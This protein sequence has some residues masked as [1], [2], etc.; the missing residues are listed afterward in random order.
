MMLPQHR[1]AA[2]TAAFVPISL[3]ASIVVTTANVTTPD[4]ATSITFDLASGAVATTLDTS[5]TLTSNGFFLDFYSH[6][7]SG[8]PQLHGAPGTSQVM[9]E[10][11]SPTAGGFPSQFA[12]RLGEGAAINGTANWSDAGA[13]GLLSKPGFVP[14][15]PAGTRGYAGL[16]IPSGPGFQYGWAD[17]SY[18]ADL[19]VT[20]HGFAVET[21]VDQTIQAGAVPEPAE[22]AFAAAMAAGSLAAFQARRRIRARRAA[23]SRS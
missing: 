2:F 12:V 13:S 21:T 9:V 11:R 3:K 5:T 18:N 10:T 17:I 4:L 6:S 22:S 15:F 20:L 23:T 19:S 1:L 8:K 16:R 14:T 7:E